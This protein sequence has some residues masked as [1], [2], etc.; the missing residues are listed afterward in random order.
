MGGDPIFGTVK[1]AFVRY[2]VGG[3]GFTT[4]VGEDGTLV[5]T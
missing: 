1:F 4:T 3:V 2:T 5:L